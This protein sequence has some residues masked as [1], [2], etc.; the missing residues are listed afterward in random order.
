MAMTE[1]QD[2]TRGDATRRETN[3]RRYRNKRQRTS[4]RTCRGC[5]LIL[6]LS[7]YYLLLSCPTPPLCPSLSSAPAS[8]WHAPARSAGKETPSRPKALGHFQGL[9]EILIRNIPLP[10][11]AKQHVQD[12]VESPHRSAAQLS[13]APYCGGIFS[14][15]CS[16]PFFLSE[17]ARC[18]LPACLRACLLPFLVPLPFW[19]SIQLQLSSL[20]CGTHKQRT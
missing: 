1:Q 6:P 14:C 2:E 15:M 18:H 13:S 12:I 17:L 16:V 5:C 20:N 19:V 8:L 3:D 4:R 10:Q 11:E 7:L 9:Q